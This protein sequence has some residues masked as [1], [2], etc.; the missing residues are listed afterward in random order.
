MTGHSPNIGTSFF[1]MGMSSVWYNWKYFSSF[2]VFWLCVDWSLP[3][4][5]FTLYIV[6][7]INDFVANSCLFFFFPIPLLSSV[8]YCGRRYFF[9]NFFF[10]WWNT[11]NLQF[12]ILIIFNCIIQWFSV[13]S[14]CDS[15]I[16]TIHLQ[17]SFH[18]TKLKLYPLDNNSPFLPSP[19]PWQPP[20]YSL[21][22]WFWLSIT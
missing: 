3:C 8:L 19:S 16:T 10:L 15:I 18:L 5:I 17:E 1:S 4:R 7:F 21:S 11:H 22:L 6:K 13:H 14:C 12:T 20:L 2:V 9:S